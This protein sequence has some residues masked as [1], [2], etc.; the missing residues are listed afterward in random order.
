MK[1][2]N[3]D[4]HINNAKFF[5]HNAKLLR[6]TVAESTPNQGNG[7]IKNATNAGPFQ[8]LSNFWKSVKVPLINCNVEFKIN[9]TKHCVLPAADND[10]TNGSPDNIIFTI[11]D[12]KLCLPVVTLSAK[13]KEK[14]SKFHVK[15]LKDKLVGMNI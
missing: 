5:K 13:D 3:A 11:K 10:N 4:I 2:F 14:L 6:N 8:Y 15:D 12:T 1:H 9:W 7:I